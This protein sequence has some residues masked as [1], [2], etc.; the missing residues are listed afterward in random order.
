M[1]PSITLYLR[2]TS[3]LVFFAHIYKQLQH[4][5]ILAMQAECDHNMNDL[6]QIK[7]C[8]LACIKK[9][10]R[11]DTFQFGV[12]R[13]KLCIFKVSYWYRIIIYLGTSWVRF[14]SDELCG[15]WAY[16][17][18]MRWTI[19]KK[20]ISWMKDIFNQILLIFVLIYLFQKM[21]KKNLLIIATFDVLCGPRTLN[22]SYMWQTI[23]LFI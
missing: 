13:K 23:T 3:L 20:T 1:A 8:L 21:S 2:E 15:Q 18:S 22:S 11:L 19:L 6:A 5:F 4:V 12:L 17:S 10:D 9:V 7:Q 14:Y 16:C